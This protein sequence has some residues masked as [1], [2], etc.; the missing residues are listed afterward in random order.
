MKCLCLLLLQCM[1]ILP[2]AAEETPTRAD[3]DWWSL[4]PL[5]LP[6]LP[7]VI[8]EERVQ[9]PIDRFILAKLEAIGMTLSSKADARTLVRRLAFDLIGLPPDAPLYKEAIPNVIDSLLES[10]R[11]GERWARHWLDVARFGESNGFEYDQLRDHAWPYR[12]WVIR[13]FNEDMPYDR[14]ARLQIAGDVLEPENPD[15]ITATSFLV[16][17]AFDG[18][19]PQGD[20]MRKIMREDEMED[21]VGTVSQSFLGL[22]MHCARCHDHKFDPIQQREYF[23]MASALA[24]VRRGDR[25]LPPRTD[26]PKDKRL[27]YAVKAVEAPVVYVLTRG[28][29]FEPAEPVSAGGVQAL[30]G[31]NPEFGLAPDAPEAQRRQELAAWITHD[32]NPLFARVMVNRLWH[33]HFGQGLVKTPNDFGFSGGKPSHPK[34][35]EWLAVQFRDSGWSLKTMHRLM[36]SSAT[37]QQL[38]QMNKKAHDIDTDN[39]LA[40]RYRPTR[41]EAEV[42]RDSILKVAGQLNPTMGGPGFRDFHM[43]KHKGSL[44]YDAIDPEGAAFNR[45][46]IYRTW[47]R[48]SIHPLLSTF[49]CPDPSATAPARSVTTTPLGAL[50]LLNDSFVL[51]M[52]DHFALRLKSEGNDASKQITQAYRHVYGRAPMPE[53]RTLTRS[54]IEK[55]GLAA[56]CRVLFNANEF[57]HVH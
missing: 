28:S 25:E 54:F 11:H 24:G 7:E 10:P 41:L 57:V 8:H 31:I 36:V 1:L 23:S 18:L 16:C 40:W 5:T 19:I 38:S 15:A 35:L 32:D 45:R 37:Y 47:A 53:E 55:H 48:G 33:Y 13:A 27:V 3:G 39:V 42:L 9:N 12:D 21:L 49:D 44:V 43:H 50:A 52:A 34:L 56:F 20:K 2:T 51:R 4:Q 30:Q 6:D 14:F 22:T 26:E 29:P 17:G 46:S